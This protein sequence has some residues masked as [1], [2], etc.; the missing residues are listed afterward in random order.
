LAQISR[1]GWNLATG[2]TM[3]TDRLRQPVLVRRYAGRRLYG[4]AAGAYLTRSDLVTVAKNGAK[5][6]VIDADTGDDVTSSYHP[7][8]VTQS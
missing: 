4:R 5:F 3:Q 8:I 6:V 2:K 1:N 7:I